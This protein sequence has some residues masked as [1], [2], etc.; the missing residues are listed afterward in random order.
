MT[1]CMVFS[2][3][4]NT[5]LLFIPKT[6]K[7]YLITSQKHIKEEISLFRN[8]RLVNREEWTVEEGTN[9]VCG[10]HTSAVEMTT[11]Y[12]RRYQQPTSKVVC[13]PIVPASCP[14]GLWFQWLT[15]EKGW[16][17]HRRQER[18][19]ERKKES[20]KCFCHTLLY[21]SLYASAI[22]SRCE[23]QRWVRISINTSF[24]QPE[25]EMT[26]TL[27][28]QTGVIYLYLWLFMFCLKTLY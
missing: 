24:S 2:F 22:M 27:N 20:T 8:F 15:W 28:Q 11:W 5:I 13:Q 6:C 23:L 14:T 18:R 9:S 7:M 17:L 4:Y 3:G 16:Q 21:M 12:S 1:L 25:K 19:K 26:Q 10:R